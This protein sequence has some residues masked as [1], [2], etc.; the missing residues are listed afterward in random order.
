ML[1]EAGRPWTQSLRLDVVCE[2]WAAPGAPKLAPERA[3]GTPWKP[4]APAGPQ[5]PR[6]ASKFR[7]VPP[8]LALVRV[9]FALRLKREVKSSR[10]LSRMLPA[11][12]PGG[13]GRH[14]RCSLCW[15]RHLRMEKPCWNLTGSLLR[16]P[17]ER[18]VMASERGTSAFPHLLA[19]CGPTASP[20]LQQDARWH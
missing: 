17:Q 1:H 8:G 11:Q 10:P 9:K 16:W 20:C 12:K 4:Q 5:L 2:V 13:L 15:P 6:C 14:Q 18:L 7:P 19:P 3:G